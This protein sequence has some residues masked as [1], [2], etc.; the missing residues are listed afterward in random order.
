MSYPSAPHQGLAAFLVFLIGFPA[1][2]DPDLQLSTLVC[3]SN[4]SY[5]S[6]ALPI[7]PHYYDIPP[8]PPPLCL[9]IA[10]LY[11][12]GVNNLFST[13]LAATIVINRT[14]AIIINFFII[15]YLFC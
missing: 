10:D 9:G 6:A 13:R 8:P 11:P 2:S 14:R 15:L 5:L 3:P 7:A 4:A 1:S 12:R